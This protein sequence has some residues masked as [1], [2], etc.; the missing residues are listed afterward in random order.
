[1]YHMDHLLTL[2][3][4][5]NAQELRFRA[6]SPPIVVSETEQRPL[7]G[8]PVTSEEVVQLLRSLASSRQIR[9]L[10]NGGIVEFVYTTRGRSPFLVR[11]KM[12][13]GNVVFDV[14]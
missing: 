9:D 14:S 10:R 13:N 6:D 7:Q 5:E 1:M 2:L 3:T 4:A 12:E 11:A 8:P